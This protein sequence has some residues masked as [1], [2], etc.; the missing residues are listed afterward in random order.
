MVFITGY[1][2]VS[3]TVE[4]MKAGAVGFLTKSVRDQQLLDAVQQATDRYRMVRHQ[5]AELTELRRCDE[6]LTQPNREVITLVMT[7]P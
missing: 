3:L 1:G 5:R 7:R 2:G 4:A 6:S